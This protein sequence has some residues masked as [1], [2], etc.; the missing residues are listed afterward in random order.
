MPS[1]TL[2]KMLYCGQGMMTLIEVYNDGVEKPAADHLALVDCGGSSGTPTDDSLNYIVTK[3]TAQA[4][5]KLA[6]VV[7]SHQDADHVRYL[8]L[9]GGMLPSGTTV[10]RMV[11]GGVQW[12]GPSK[13][14]VSTF[15]KAVGY[16]EKD[17][18]WPAKGGSDYP[19]D[20]DAGKVGYQSKLGDT[21]LRLVVSG[22]TVGGVDIKNVSSAVI[23]VDN[24]SYRAVLPGDAT[25]ETMRY[26]NKMTNIA[27]LLRPVVAVSIPHHGALRTA[28]ENY[29]SYSKGGRVDDFDYDVLEDFADTLDATRAGASAGPYN[30]HHHPMEEVMDRFYRSTALSEEHKYVSWMFDDQDWKGWKARR[31]AYSTVQRIRTFAE[32]DTVGKKSSND[33]GA[34]IYGDVVCKL[35]APGVLRDEEMVEF[36][37]RGTL[38]HP[39]AEDPVRY[40]QEP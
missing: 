36:R 14:A 26:V 2:V 29:L 37:P 22:L 3:V 30:S 25:V 28:V 9:L 35:A 19:D 39:A 12:G 23:A 32:N 27:T 11:L 10:D 17:I 15:A 16:D 18:Y 5:K 1:L 33:H 38:G 7:I 20:G 31:A 8:G 21:Y 13:G 6:C 24:G 4:A 40:A 34:F